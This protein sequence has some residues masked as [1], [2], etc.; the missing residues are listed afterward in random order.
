MFDV[1]NLVE[2]IG[3]PDFSR[4]LMAAALAASIP[5]EISQAAHSNQWATE[6]LFYCL[7]DRDEEIREQQLLFVAQNMGTDS[8]SRVRGLWSAAPEPGAGSSVCP[9]LK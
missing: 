2:Q 1:D 8:E 5:E 7:M 4:I 3:H 9:C 6:V